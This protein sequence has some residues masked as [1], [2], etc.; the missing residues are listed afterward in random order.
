MGLDSV[1]LILEAEESFGISLADDEMVEI[2]T[3]G[4]FYD[5]IMRELPRPEKKFCL[6]AIAFHKLRRALLAVTDGQPKEIRPSTRVETLLP[7]RG[8][9][10]PGGKCSGYQGCDFPIFISRHGASLLP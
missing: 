6:S 9:R 10:L 7:R 1:E 8:A 2:I 5:A 4:Q 3:V